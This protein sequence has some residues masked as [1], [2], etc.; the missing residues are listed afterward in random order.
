MQSG[1]TVKAAQQTQANN[2]KKKDKKKNNHWP[3]SG[4]AE[5]KYSFFASPTKRSSNQSTA[6]D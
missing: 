3:Q 4:R 1:N 5:D 6:S 2:K